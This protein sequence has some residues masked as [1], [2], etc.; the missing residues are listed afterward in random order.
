VKILNS[1]EEVS[2]KSAIN[3][4]ASANPSFLAW[5]HKFIMVKP[6]VVD[7]TINT[8]NPKTDPTPAEADQIPN[9]KGRKSRKT[10]SSENGP[11]TKP[12]SQPT[13]TTQQTASPICHVGSKR[14]QQQSPR[15]SP[16]RTAALSDVNIMGG[17]PE[18]SLTPLK[19]KEKLKLLSGKKDLTPYQASHI[20]EDKDWKGEMFDHKDIALVLQGPDSPMDWAILYIIEKQS[21]LDL[22]NLDKIKMELSKGA[23]MCKQPESSKFY[24]GH[25]PFYIKCDMEL[26]GV[27]N[28]NGKEVAVFPYSRYRLPTGEFRFDLADI[29]THDTLCHLNLSRLVDKLTSMKNGVGPVAVLADPKNAPFHFDKAGE[30]KISLSSS[31]G[32]IAT[33]DISELNAP[34][35][36]PVASST[37]IRF[38]TTDTRNYNKKDTPAA[39][40]KNSYGPLGGSFDNG[41]DGDEA[42]AVKEVR[43]ETNAN[44]KPVENSPNSKCPASKSVDEMSNEE[45]NDRSYLRHHTSLC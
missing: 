13:T 20:I 25:G 23:S 10:D 42:G 28:K 40:S 31:L 29:F 15:A 1:V 34:Q 17:D 6:I 26:I 38:G 9:S 45:F 32:V 43:E 27:F 44:S 30:G 5:L 41:E 36:E 7:N 8:T 4:L 11:S 3:R 33:I 21:E 12:Q 16:Q 14:H 35:D 2:V 24:H 39:T 37:K 18:Q 22:V 19:L